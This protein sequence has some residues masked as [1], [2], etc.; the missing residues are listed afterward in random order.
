MKK[1]K[2]KKRIAVVMNNFLMGGVQR[3]FTFLLPHLDQGKF[4]FFLITLFNSPEKEALYRDLPAQFPVYKLNFKGFFDII[5]WCKLARIF[6]KIKPSIVLSNLFFSNTV[7]RSLK[8]FLGYKVITCEHNTY[9]N[10]RR[11]HVFLDKIL[12][13]FSHKIV[14]VSKTVA[15]FTSKQEKIPISKF[16]VIY[17]GI[18]LKKIE[19]VKSQMPSKEEMK[20]RLG[21]QSSDRI[22]I[23]VARLAPQK[24]HGFLIHAFAKFSDN[25]PEYKLIILGDGGLRG[26]LK[27]IIKKV[28]KENNIFL[29]GNKS[30]VFD[31]YYISDFFVSTSQIEGLSVAYLEAMA[32]DLPL[33]STK[34]AGTDEL[35]IDGENG[36][37]IEELSVG[38]ILNNIEKMTSVDYAYFKKNIVT[39]IKEFDI[40]TTAE[41]YSLL[42]E[43]TLS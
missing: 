9:I 14:A 42:F 4:E 20:K 29:L 38:N 16:E 5:S 27:K 32:F 8:P 39:T 35:I 18:D 30:N 17:N 26:K 22:I 21:F 3:Q 19:K 2:R 13:V 43:K 40:K 15:D 7:V 12:S 6:L 23:N 1:E 11:I 41:K 10:K 37:F 24:K 36:L 31:Y 28:N 34:T 25:Y 33:V